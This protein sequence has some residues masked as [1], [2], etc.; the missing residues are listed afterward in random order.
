METRTLQGWQTSIS[1]VISD[2]DTE[3]T[4]I[5]GHS[6]NELIGNA[7]FAET[8]F[9]LL[10]GKMPT[11]KQGVVLDALLVSCIEH[12]IAP[13][14]LIP[15]LYASYG[16]GLQHGIAGGISAFGEKMGALGEKMAKLMIDKL[17]EAAAQDDETLLTIAQQ[18]VAEIMGSGER[19]PGFGIPLH[20]RDPRADRVIEI[21]KENGVYGTY[22]RFA[23]YLSDAI[24]DHRS[25][26]PVPLNIDGVCACIALDLGFNWRTTQMFLLTSRSVSMGAHYLEELS[27]DTIWRHIPADQIDYSGA[28][29]KNRET[30]T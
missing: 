14:S 23:G 12:G 8:M 26:R 10:N 17:G 19:V 7:T 30:N 3:D 16:T 22:C 5:R 27:Q 24:T 18:T 25:G 6:L 15:R 13:P 1:R 9:L 2:G 11:K 4:L 20:S 21:A 28:V 29:A